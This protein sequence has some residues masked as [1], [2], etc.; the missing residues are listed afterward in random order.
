MTD[1]NTHLLDPTKELTTEELARLASEFG[2]IVTPE[3]NKT[4]NG[5]VPSQVEPN[6]VN[7]DKKIKSIQTPIDVSLKLT[8]EQ[9]ERLQRLCSNNS[10]STQQYITDVVLKDLEASVGRA[11]ITGPSRIGNVSVGRKVVGPSQHVRGM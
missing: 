6:Y 3:G 1:I 10:M 7:L 9:H 11:A 4:P 5:D 8:P 2:T